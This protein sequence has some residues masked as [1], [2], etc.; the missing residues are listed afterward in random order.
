MLSIKQEMAR[1]TVDK[2][3]NLSVKEMKVLKQHVVHI[4]KNSG[5]KKKCRIFRNLSLRN[6]SIYLMIQSLSQ[7]VK[8]GFLRLFKGQRYLWLGE[9]D[10]RYSQNVLKWLWSIFWIQMID[11]IKIRTLKPKTEI[12]SKT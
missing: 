3:F 12:P 11:C 9:T 7:G 2:N 6:S 10:L 8:D 4:R 5:V 1:K